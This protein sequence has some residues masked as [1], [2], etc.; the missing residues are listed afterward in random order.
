[1]CLLVLCTPSSNSIAQM[2]ALVVY[3]SV[4][5]HVGEEGMRLVMV[6]DSD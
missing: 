3:L 2:S 4:I 6:E 5:T 1:M